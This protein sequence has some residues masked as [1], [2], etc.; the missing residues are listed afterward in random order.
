L[1]MSKHCLVGTY[2]VRPGEVLKNFSLTF[3]GQ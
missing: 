3:T 1:L 2:K